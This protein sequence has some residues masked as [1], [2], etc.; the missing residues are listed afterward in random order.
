MD[1]SQR[2]RAFWAWL[3]VFRVVAETEHLPQAAKILRVSPSSISRTI[4]LLEAELGHPLFVRQNRELRLSA[5]GAQF[6]GSVRDAMRLVD[7]GLGRLNAQGFSGSLTVAAPAWLG[8]RL[9]APELLRLS[10]AHPELQPRL[11]APPSSIERALLRGEMDLVIAEAPVTGKEIEV[12]ELPSLPLRV[13]V[14]RSVTPR[15]QSYLAPAAVSLP[16]SRPRALEAD[17]DVALDLCA[18]GEVKALLPAAVARERPS[19]EAED[20][21][22]AGTLRLHALRRP[23]LG[24]EGAVG[25]ILERLKER[26]TGWA[27][28]GR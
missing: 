6:L 24:A 14:A 1:R 2:L 19:L 20:E 11:I 22:R 3:P 10:R 21:E 12:V 26:L 9:L 23:P 13:Y 17:V 4:R 27:R 28:L 8:R 5:E 7:D 25:L 16:K 18:A 15:P